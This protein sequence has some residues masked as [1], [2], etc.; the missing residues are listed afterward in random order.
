MATALFFSSVMPWG[1]LICA[2]GT[3][4]NFWVYKLDFISRSRTPRILDERFTDTM[5]L[6]LECM[7]YV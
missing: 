5:V 4:L 2:V 1:L 7:L 3:L 6:L